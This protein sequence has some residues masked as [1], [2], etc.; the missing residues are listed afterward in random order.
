MTSASDTVINEKLHDHLQSRT[1]TVGA[2]L[3]DCTAPVTESFNTGGHAITVSAIVASDTARASILTMVSCSFV[4]S[5]VPF[6]RTS[7]LS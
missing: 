4:K 6:Q 5:I 3:T 2:I 7:S 1:F